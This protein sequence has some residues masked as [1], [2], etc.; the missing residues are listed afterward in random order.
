MWVVN[1]V[2]CCGGFFEDEF[3]VFEVVDVGEVGGFFWWEKKV[4]VVYV[5]RFGDVFFDEFIEWLIG[6]DFDEVVEDIGGEVVLLFV[7]RLVV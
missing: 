7:V 5:E 2:V 3:F 6:D 1:E 4:G